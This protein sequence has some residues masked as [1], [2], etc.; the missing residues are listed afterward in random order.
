MTITAPPVIE[1]AAPVTPS[2]LEAT[3]AQA[4]LIL[5]GVVLTAILLPETDRS[6]DSRFDMPGAATLAAG[7]GGI[8]IAVT[9]AGTNGVTGQVIVAA[10]VGVVALAAFAAIE[11]RADDRSR[12]G[13]S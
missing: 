10:V 13:L 1:T 8:L 6:G 5:L 2:L 11:V 9:L 3:L 7:V 4:P 12:A